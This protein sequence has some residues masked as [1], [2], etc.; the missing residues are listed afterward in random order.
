MRGLQ[1]GAPSK[2]PNPWVRLFCTCIPNVKPYRGQQHRTCSDRPMPA[3]LSGNRLNRPEETA[4]IVHQSRTLPGL[5][6]S[7]GIFTLLGQFG[8]RSPGATLKFG[9]L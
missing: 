5:H 1:P 7:H 3:W 8:Q 4:S 2:K 6:R 9:V